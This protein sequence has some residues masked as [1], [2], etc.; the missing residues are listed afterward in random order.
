MTGQLFGEGAASVRLLRGTAAAALLPGQQAA[1]FRPDRH[2]PLRLAF[3]DDGPR[4]FFRDARKF[5]KVQLLEPGQESSRLSRLGVDALAMSADA[6]FAAR[7]GR[8]VAIKSLLLDQSVVAAGPGDDALILSVSGRSVPEG[9]EFAD[10][11]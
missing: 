11:P 7:R 2:T 5:G 4:V 6:L 3:D 1:A 9:L 10:L 8:R